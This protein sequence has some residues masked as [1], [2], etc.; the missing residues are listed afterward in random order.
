MG[1][2][3]LKSV[4]TRRL[5]K[6]EF[7]TIEKDALSK[8][9][10][11]GIQATGIRAF[12]AKESF[13]D[14]D[15]LIVYDES[16][17]FYK[18]IIEEFSPA[19]VFSNEMKRRNVAGKIEIHFTPFNEV[20]VISFDYCS[21]QVDFILID[22]RFF[23]TAEVYYSF[24]DLG[25]L[26]GRIAQ[27][28]G[29]KYGHDGLSIKTWHESGAYLGHIHLSA[30]PFEIFD[31]LGY[32]YRRFLSGFETLNDIFDY[33][34]SSRF[35]N[36]DIFLLENRNHKGRSRDRKRP[37]YSAFLEYCKS[38]D[39]PS[40]FVFDDD[41]S[42]YFDKV[43]KFFPHYEA[44]KAVLVNQYNKERLFAKRINGHVV[45]EITGL[46]KGEDLGSFLKRL[47]EAFDIDT[48][49]EMSDEDIRLMVLVEYDKHLSI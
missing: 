36:P 25:N 34:V 18:L 3:A 4:E 40:Y 47:K 9:V 24:N 26:M 37:S 31:F 1:G 46:E 30:N 29:T 5:D 17:D 44:E 2:N 41:K 19:E 22:K 33:V 39:R 8:L 6:E 23:E 20:R 28:F 27:G 49:S 48:V 21:F 7:E 13:G 32:D 45:S 11:L 10:A 15:V 43:S 16:I 38:L 14:L 35:F 12:S 42:V